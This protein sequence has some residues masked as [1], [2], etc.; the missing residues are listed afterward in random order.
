MTL[1]TKGNSASPKP[2]ITLLA[3]DCWVV[4]STRVDPSKNNKVTKVCYYCT[5]S[6]WSSSPLSA[7]IFRRWDDAQV[8][9]HLCDKDRPP[10]GWADGSIEYFDAVTLYGSVMEKVK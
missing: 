8:Q 5:P 7:T 10:L 6:C 2:K 9:V 1:I 3:E 4:R